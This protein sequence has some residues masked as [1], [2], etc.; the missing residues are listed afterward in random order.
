M[1]NLRNENIDTY[2]V[3]CRV[4]HLGFPVPLLE[5]VSLTSWITPNHEHGYRVI[6]FCKRFQTKILQAWRFFICPAK[7]M[8]VVL[9]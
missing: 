1:W 4:A 6:R 7:F 2:A 8:A 3:Y 9:F 5:L